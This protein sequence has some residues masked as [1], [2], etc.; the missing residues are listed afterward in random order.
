MLGVALNLLITLVYFHPRPFMEGIGHALINHADET[1][2]PSD[3]TTLMLSIALMLLFFK[4]TRIISSI[5]LA[6][7]LIGG[8]ARVFCGIHYPFD[9]AGSLLVAFVSAVI[10]W[11]LREKLWIVNTIIINLYSRLFSPKST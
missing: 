1:S 8:F 4:S 2:F 3:H 10:I 6:F 9:I 7:G 11:S 5:F